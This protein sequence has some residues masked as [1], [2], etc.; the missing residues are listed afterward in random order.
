MSEIGTSFLQ[1]PSGRRHERFV[2]DPEYGR[3]DLT[4]PDDAARFQR[5][6]ELL[7]LNAHRRQE[8]AAARERE[9]YNRRALFELGRE[10]VYLCIEI[11]AVGV[12]ALIAGL[13]WVGGHG[14]ASLG[15]LG[16][17]QG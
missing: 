10:Q 7:M 12:F 2:H 6:Q 3:F 1:R 13:L 16:G 4:D 5:V 17:G 14:E 15:A 11:A 8:E 9:I